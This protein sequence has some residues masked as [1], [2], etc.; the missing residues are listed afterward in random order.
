MRF[1]KILSLMR[2]FRSDGGFLGIYGVWEMGRMAFSLVL[3]VSWLGLYFVE[4]LIFFEFIVFFRIKNFFF[5]VVLLFLFWGVG[6]G[7]FG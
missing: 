7:V 2:N 5:R 3:I 4:L 6:G 1:F